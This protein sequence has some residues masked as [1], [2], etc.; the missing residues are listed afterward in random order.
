MKVSELQIESLSYGDKTFDYF[1]KNTTSTADTDTAV[2]Y[3]AST[4]YTWG[5]YVKIASLKRKF[6]C[7]NKQGVTGKHPVTYL[8]IDWVDA[9]AINEFAMFDNT[10][11]STATS[12]TDFNVSMDFDGMNTITIQNTKNITAIQIVQTSTDG[13]TTYYDSGSI[14]MRD[15]GRVSYHDYYTR[16]IIDNIKLTKLDGIV[17]KGASKLTIYFT[18]AQSSTASVGMIGVGYAYDL[19]CTLYGTSV[20][21]DDY[22]VYKTDEFGFTTFD[23]RV[24]IDTIDGKVVIENNKIDYAIETLKR[25]RGKLSHYIGDERETGKLQSLDI[26]AYAKKLSIPINNP[27]L[28]EFPIKLIGGA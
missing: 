8:D 12:T 5:E 9:G 2:E 20:G 7:A 4:S 27:V 25:V 26:I 14:S 11:S 22:S 23:K 16:P 13:L 1:C 3:D 6:R 21:Y 10:I 15:V 24:A 28:N 17:W 19:G 18:I